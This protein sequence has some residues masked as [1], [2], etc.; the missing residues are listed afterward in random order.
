ML[1]PVAAAALTGALAAQAAPRAVPTKDRA[2]SS[3][4]GVQVVCWPKAPWKA[5]TAELGFAGAQG[6][7]D[8]SSRTVHLP[9]RLCRQLSLIRSM[10]RAQA[11]MPEALLILAHELAHI[12]GVRDEDEATCAGARRMSHWARA[13]GA[14]RPYAHRLAHDWTIQD[15][16][17]ACARGS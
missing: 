9:E 15:Y 12:G 6:F 7:T 3:A 10:P 11:R 13:L 4:L 16:L 14:T 17:T 2:L 1:A 8:L 5:R